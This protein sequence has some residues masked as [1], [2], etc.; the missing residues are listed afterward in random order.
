MSRSATRV[1][2]AALRRAD[3]P[4]AAL[5]AVRWVPADVVSK[6]PFLGASLYQ[7]AG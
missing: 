7:V 5:P 6:A 2:G 1:P 3:V 4:F